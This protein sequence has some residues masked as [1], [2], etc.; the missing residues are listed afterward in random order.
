MKALFFFFALLATGYAKEPRLQALLDETCE[1]YQ[2]PSIAASVFR[3]DR[4]LEEAVTGK[5]K[6]GSNEKATLAD[7]YH[8]GSITK[9]MTASVAAILVEEKIIRWESTIGEILGETCPSIHQLYRDVTLRELC[10]HRAGMP[11][12]VP[13]DLWKL[14]H[15]RG[16]KFDDRKNRAWL[17]GEILQRPP[18]QKRGTFVYANSGYICAGMMLE[19]ATGKPWQQLMKKKLFEPLQMRSAGFGPGAISP[20][21]IDQP[22]PHVDRSPIAP[23]PGADN[24]PALGPAGTVHCSI[25]DLARYGSWHLAAGKQKLLPS[26]SSSGFTLLHESRYFTAK[27]DGYALG[28]QQMHRSWAGA[29]ALTHNGTN[30]MNYAVIWLAPDRDLGIAL[31]CN[32]GRHDVAKA[33]DEIASAMVTKY[34]TR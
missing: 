19:I 11:H 31:V 27:D 34:A 33:L 2:L 26:L 4:V 9:S 3:K 12:D 18:T 20:T 15:Q 13:P 8:L 29:Y 7:V 30:T 24:P 5:R 23:G 10:E 17:I 28:W 22:W 32:E 1:K 14:T 21:V 6:I 25:G 16:E